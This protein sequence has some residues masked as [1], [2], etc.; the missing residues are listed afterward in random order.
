MITI[1]VTKLEVNI[2]R[3]NL[4]KGLVEF[5][6]GLNQFDVDESVCGRERKQLEELGLPFIEDNPCL[7]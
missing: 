3:I 7:I 6:S 2:R 5:L 1:A 4:L